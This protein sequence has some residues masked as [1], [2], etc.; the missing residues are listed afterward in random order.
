MRLALEL[1]G[2]TLGTV[3]A[4]RL[5]SSTGTLLGSYLASHALNS[6]VHA[7][8][9]ALAHAGLAA[10]LGTTRTLA[11]AATTVG[12][13][14]HIAVVIAVALAVATCLLKLLLALGLAALGLLLHLKGRRVALGVNGGR[15]G[16]HMQVAGLVDVGRLV[17]ELLDLVELIHVLLSH[18]RDGPA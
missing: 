5:L 6:L 2:T 17:H 4:R 12:T 7:S 11:V 1:L 13:T 14:G 9:N 18:K 15:I 3:T 10:A 8:L 16:T